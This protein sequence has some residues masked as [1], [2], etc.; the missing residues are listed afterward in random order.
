MKTVFMIL[1]LM[2][3]F[4]YGMPQTA[5]VTEKIPPE[6]AAQRLILQ[7]IQKQTKEHVLVNVSNGHFDR[8]RAQAND[9]FSKAFPGVS[10]S[11]EKTNAYTSLI[12]E[13]LG[14]AR[15]SAAATRFPE[16][17]LL[18]VHEILEGDLNWF[19]P[20]PPPWEQRFALCSPLDMDPSRCLSHMRT[21]LLGRQTPAFNT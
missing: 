16:N 13:I 10:M 15:S 8:E 21:Y 18:K 14:Q 5:D 4:S 7:T 17:Q 3:P 20:I 9:L 2:R 12:F 6:W 1:A 11:V 19:S